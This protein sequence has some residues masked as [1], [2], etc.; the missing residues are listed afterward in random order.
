VSP[1]RC[2][3]NCAKV[4]NGNPACAGVVE[5]T[6]GVTFFDAPDTCCDSKF[7][8]Y[9][10]TMCTQL[11]V[12]G[13][14]AATHKWYVSYGSSNYVKDCPAFAA[15]PEC[16]G[17]PENLG[18]KLF[19]T[20]EKCCA[21]KLNWIDAAAC[22]GASVGTSAG[23]VAPVTA[24][25]ATGTNKW[26]VDYTGKKCEQ[27]I[28]EAKPGLSLYDTMED[29]C[30]NKLSY[31]T[32]ELC[33]ARSDGGDGHSGKYYPVAGEDVCKKDCPATLGAPCA[34]SPSDLSAPLYDDPEACCSNSLGW[35]DAESCHHLSIIGSAAAT[36]RWLGNYGENKCVKDCATES[37]AGCAG[38]VENKAGLQTFS[39]LDDCCTKTLGYITKEICIARSDGGDGH[40]G[41]FYPTQPENVCKMDCPA[42]LGSPCAGAPSDLSTAVYHDL[43]ACC[44]NS[45]GW[46]DSTSCLTMTMN[47]SSVSVTGTDE[48]YVDWTSSQCVKNCPTGTGAS[49]SCGGLKESWDVSFATPELCCV[50]LSWKP[51]AE[52][53]KS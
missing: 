39:T 53:T 29:C 36:N 50:Q 34:G 8:W 44:T 27:G 33:H 23:A 1:A 40:S 14:Y 13:G 12:Y 49:S 3:M 47:L 17:N 25:A 52:C 30:A 41:K 4:A 15:N 2:V 35:V 51:L 22:A 31:I 32:K 45:I 5:A 46:E 38:I 21:A 6:A 26:L 37:G 43:E 10:K 42:S 7:G 11:S 20:A 24:T 16:K 48:W 19:L 9:D 28:V 18:E